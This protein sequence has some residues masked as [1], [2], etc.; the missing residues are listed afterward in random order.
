MTLSQFVEGEAPQAAHQPL[1]DPAD[2]FH[3][4]I[5]LLRQSLE[6]KDVCVVNSFQQLFQCDSSVPVTLQFGQRVDL[7]FHALEPDPFS[8]A[9]QLDVGSRDNHTF[10]PRCSI[11]Q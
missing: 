6:Y 11:P 3:I 8:A 10:H 5:V 4:D 1:Q 7:A 2:I 9:I